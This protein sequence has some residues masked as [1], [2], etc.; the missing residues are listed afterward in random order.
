MV[1]KEIVRVAPLSVAKILA[2]IYF[3]L[4]AF[5]SPLTSILPQDLSHPRGPTGFSFIM[6]FIYAIMGFI[7]TICFAG[8]YNFLAK[9]IGGVR[10]QTVER[11][12]QQTVSADTPLPVS[13]D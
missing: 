12:V 3:F 9:R 13:R 1:M 8:L 11:E 2:V 7:L 4:G 10:F 5:T 6:P